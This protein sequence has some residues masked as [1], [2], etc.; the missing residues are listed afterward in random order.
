MGTLHL[1]VYP[2]CG[3]LLCTVAILFSAW[4]TKKSCSLLLKAG[5]VAR[6]RNYEGL[7]ELFVGFMG[8]PIV[9]Y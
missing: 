7:G 8:F 4:L 2:Q 1:F 9:F 6:R 3:I 5:Q